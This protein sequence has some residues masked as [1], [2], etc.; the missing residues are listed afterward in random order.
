MKQM[1][2]V[3][4]IANAILYEGYML[5]PYRRSALKNQRPGWSFG[6][7]VPPAYA[8]ANPGESATMGAEVLARTTADARVTVEARFLQLNAPES[9]AAIERTVEK[10]AVSGELMACRRET[11][12]NFPSPA[13]SEKPPISGMLELSAERINEDVLKIKLNLHNDSVLESECPRRDEILPQSL[14]A[15]HAL[16]FIENGEFVSLLD[17]PESLLAQAAA[18]H[19]SGVFP[20]LTGDARRR[21]AVLLSPIILY[22]YPQIAPESRG[23]FFDSFE[24]DEMLTL[25]VLTLSDAEKNEVRSS[26]EHGL[27]ILRRA[28]SMM[29]EEIL[30]LHGA[31]R[32]PESKKE[33]Q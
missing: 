9:N 30:K 12:F 20:V 26:G 16:V 31:Y 10:Q 8:A 27:Q 6:T 7:L 24:I 21:N 5:Y 28:E 11:Q 32:E 33:E 1:E 22:D 19:Q 3:R 2:E 29:P 13:D 17:P 15:A 23:D 14:V 4:A 25:R 18:C